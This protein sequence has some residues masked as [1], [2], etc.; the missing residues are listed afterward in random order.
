MPLSPTQLSC[1]WPAEESVLN[2]SLCLL[3]LTSGCFEDIQNIQQEIVTWLTPPWGQQVPWQ[4]TISGV[5]GGAE[6]Q[7]EASEDQAEAS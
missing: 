6:E 7:A 4:P 3:L 1:L 2:L 5:S